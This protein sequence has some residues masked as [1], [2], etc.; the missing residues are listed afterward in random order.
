M[1]R[2]S[3]L[4][5]VPVILTGCLF[6]SFE[7]RGYNNWSSCGGIVQAEIYNGGVLAGSREES[8][9]Y[10]YGP[11]PIKIDEIHGDLFGVPSKIE[12]TCQNKV[13]GV[14][15]VVESTSPVQAGE[16]FSIFSNRLAK[17][18]GK[19]DESDR[20]DGRVQNFLCGEPA[21]VK[22][23]LGTERPDLTKNDILLIVTPYSGV[24]VP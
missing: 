18:F 3:S 20:D 13:P 2:H 19:P 6:A 9:D 15:Y 22:L 14:F 21:S 8:I 23:I 1:L 11:E 4:L 5:L 12:V 7:F 24:C 16:R 17:E 10:G